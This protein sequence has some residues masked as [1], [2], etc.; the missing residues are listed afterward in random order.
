MALTTRQILTTLFIFTATLLIFGMDVGAQDLLPPTASSFAEDIDLI[1]W[2]ILGITTFFFIL[3]FVLLIYFMI[4][5]RAKK[6]G[7]EGINFHGHLGLEIAWTIIPAVLFVAIAIYS[8]DVLNQMDNPPEGALVVQVEG[9]Q[10]GWNFAYEA[11]TP[12]GF[13]TTQ[14]TLHLP[15][16]EPVVL[17]II[18]KDVLHSFWVPAFRLK[19]DA[20]PDSMRILWFEPTLEGTYPVICAE[21]CGSGHSDMLAKVIVESRAEYDAWLQDEVDRIAGQDPAV[22]RGEQVATELGCLACHSK[23]GTRTV[24]P[25]WLDL[26]GKEES[27][28]D[29]TTAVVDEAYLIESI[30]DPNAQ[31]VATYFA[32]IMQPYGPDAVSD[33]QLSDIIAYIRSL[34]SDGDSTASTGDSGTDTSDTTDNTTDTGDPADNTDTTDTSDSGD[35]TDTTSDISLADRGQEL[36]TSQTCIGCHSVDGNPSLGPTWL[37]LY[38]KS[39][40]LTDGTTVTV[41]DEYIVTAIRDPGAHIPEGFTP[42]LMQPFNE[43]Q[44]SDEDIEAIIE[45][46]KTLTN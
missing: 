1:F 4:R 29:G 14:N 25:S 27:L 37:G 45:Y 28:D 5:Y 35:N 19:Q 42:G 22:Q 9:V 44:L 6:P 32:N 46:I 16:N 11:N 34:T 38:G 8:A 33:E 26:F 36:Y 41:D 7:E 39:Q 12:S 43:S 21:L 30:R 15:V 24:G 10:F 40:A 2:V 20:L 23:D 31:I 3:V 17:E 18:S 13:V